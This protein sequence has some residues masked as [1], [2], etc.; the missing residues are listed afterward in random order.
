MH[1]FISWFAVLVLVV[2]GSVQDHIVQ[3]AEVIV[4]EQQ[5]SR[6]H[7][8]DQRIRSACFWKKRMCRVR[9][10]KYVK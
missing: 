7:W 8:V 2:S 1:G 9:Y 4:S 6:Y 10:N 5:I 3:M